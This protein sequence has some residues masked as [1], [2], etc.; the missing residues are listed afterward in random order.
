MT[1]GKI[2]APYE[3]V[4]TIIEHPLLAL[5]S[6]ESR[7]MQKPIAPSIPVS[8]RHDGLFHGW[9]VNARLVD[10]DDAVWKRANSEEYLSVA[11]LH[12]AHRRFATPTAKVLTRGDQ[13]RKVVTLTFDDGPHPR[14]TPRLLKVLAENRTKATFFVVGEMVEKYPA[15]ARAIVAEGHEI[16]NHTFSH[17]NLSKLPEYLVR[18]EYRAASDVI[19]KTTGKRPRYARPPG[20]QLNTGVLQ[21]ATA[22]GMTT[23]L[24]N[25]DPGDYANPGQAV[26]QRNIQRTLS[27]GAIFLLHDGAVEMLDL[28][29]GLIR[30]LRQT[31][32]QI[33]SLSD[34]VRPTQT[35]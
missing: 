16:A 24:W 14:F 31:G 29:P 27:N 21:A 17:V 28:L 26:L 20:G 5:P 25:V 32:W 35:T 23:V 8:K 1:G 7:I 3:T 6:P 10:K 4:W 11:R 12:A 2:T 19:Q 13:Q 22:E 33:T 9:L 18:V 15:M 34:I 30:N